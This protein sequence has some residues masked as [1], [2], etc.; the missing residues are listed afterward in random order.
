MLA[1]IFFPTVSA[2]V[3]DDQPDTEDLT[4]FPSGFLALDWA[5]LVLSVLF[6]CLT[7]LFVFDV[8]P[9]GVFW[10]DNDLFKNSGA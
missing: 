10:F 8:I 2:L 3:S 9:M 5:S 4:H 1:G 7:H 6:S